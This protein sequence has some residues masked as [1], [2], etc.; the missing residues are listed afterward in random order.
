MNFLI[1]NRILIMFG[2]I[3]Q[4]NGKEI[5]GKK[6]LTEGDI[7]EIEKH[8]KNLLIMPGSSCMEGTCQITGKSFPDQ[9][10]YVDGTTV[11]C[12]TGLHETFDTPRYVS[13]ITVAN[14]FVW[15]A[16]IFAFRVMAHRK[17][18]SI[19]PNEYRFVS[20]NKEGPWKMRRSDGS[21]R[22]CN[23][24]HGLRWS[25]D[26]ETGKITWYIRVIYYGEGHRREVYGLGKKAK[27]TI[28]HIT[29]GDD[30]VML[31]WFPLNRFMGI[32]QQAELSLSV[33]RFDCEPETCPIRKT[34]KQ[35]TN[36]FYDLD[37]EVLN[38]ATSIRG[39]TVNYIT[40]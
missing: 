23:V 2:I 11:V 36:M 17:Y 7:P 38:A 9:E 39:V 21:I 32:N 6:E 8:L 25:V 4:V 5:F 40:I 20:I 34:L 29:F 31:K 13:L 27:P 24:T 1:K 18:F 22:L 3:H 16:R 30:G 12:I 28:N 19:R 14:E 33:G 10:S 15:L 37:E 35:N 26:K